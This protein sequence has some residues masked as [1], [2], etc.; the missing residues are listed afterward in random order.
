MA[1]FIINLHNG[2]LHHQKSLVLS[3]LNL[4]ISHGEFCYLIG[5]TGSGKTS[6][7]RSLYGDLI[8]RHGEGF[9]A[10]Y[11]LLKLNARNIPYL[12]RKLGIIFQDFQLLTDRSVHDNL[13]FVMRATGWRNKQLID[14]RIKEVLKMVSLDGKAYKMPHELSGGEQQKVVIARALINDPLLI[15]ADEPTGN[16]DPEISEELVGLLHKIS[17]EG[18]AVI[19]ATHDY[20]LIEKFPARVLKV[21]NQTLSELG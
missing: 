17:K 16:L 2:T 12:R 6:L 20:R 3:G 11:D 9:V 10:G 13:L 18:T 4:K 15:I 7:L 5:R 21:E 19:M 8:M 1:D 14:N